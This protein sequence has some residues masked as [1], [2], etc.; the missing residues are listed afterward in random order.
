[1]SDLGRLPT[2]QHRADLLDLDLRPTAE[3]VELV[4][5][6]SL[7]AV[8]AVGAAAGALA[9]AVDAAAARLRDGDGRM[10]HVG[11][12]T[13]G[14]LGVLDATEVP[15]T[16]DS[17]RVVGLL[18]GGAGAV[19][20]AEEAAEDDATAAARDLDA[21]GVGRGDVVVGVSASGRTPYTVA[22]VRH[23]AER[24]ALTIGVTSNPDA[25]VSRHVH[26]PIETLTGPELIAGSTRLKAG[27]AQ[28][29]V[30]NTL[31][32]LVM[33]RLGRTFGNLMVDVRAT[34]EKLRDRARRIV[35]D[36]TGC[37]ADE[38]ARTL[39]AA[40]G[41]A[42]TAIVALLADVDVEEAAA[43]LRRTDGRVRPA[44]DG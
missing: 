9:A 14:R 42:K 30:L 1:M 16:F 37:G 15:P 17:E 19:S 33:V 7:E 10:I 20:G 26:H 29:V 35:E 38:A 32:T 34:N 12:G 43:R 44:L 27:T 5:R 31:S 23:A 13:A 2:E 6:D 8:E 41:D 40:G 21:L 22:A 39:D 28:K 36:A 25:E 11:A 4:V 24:G 18:A 3:L